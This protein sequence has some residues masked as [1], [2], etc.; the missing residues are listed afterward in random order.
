MSALSDLARAERWLKRCAI[1]VWRANLDTSPEGAGRWERA[2][3]RLLRAGLSY[4][5]EAERVKKSAPKLGRRP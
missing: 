1:G 5:Y 3:E 2:K 4:G